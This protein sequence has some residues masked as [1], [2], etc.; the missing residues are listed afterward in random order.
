MPVAQHEQWSQDLSQQTDD[1]A[2]GRLETALAR[3]A[4]AAGR[5]QDELRVAELNA[6]AAQH[7]ADLL[8]RTEQERMSGAA[9]ERAAADAAQAAGREEHLQA[10]ANRLDALIAT[11]RG[12]IGEPVEVAS[13]TSSFEEG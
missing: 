10:L 8:L 9:V 2:I 3:I 6:R 1:G 5:R 4:T 12:A 7:E 11:V 13:E